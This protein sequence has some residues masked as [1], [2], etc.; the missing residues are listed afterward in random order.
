VSIHLT[1]HH[2]A[3]HPGGLSMVYF[4]YTSVHIPAYTTG[5]IGFYTSCH[6]VYDILTFITS[7]FQCI[8]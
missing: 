1:E 6:L 7:C 4:V 8:I 2:K 5:N 3:I